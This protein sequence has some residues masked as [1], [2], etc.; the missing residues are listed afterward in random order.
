MA[1][2]NFPSSPSNGDF[3]SANGKTWQYNGTSWE[4][5]ADTA[6]S[7][8]LV[9]HS[10]IN[11][12]P[13]NGLIGGGNITSNVVLN[14]DDPYVRGLFSGT[15]SISYNSST[16]EIA[17]TGNVYTKTQVDALLL[18]KVSDS[19]NVVAGDG[20]YGGGDLSTNVTLNISGGYGITVETDNI[21][22]TASDV[23]NLFSAAGDIS[24]NSTTGEF[25]FTD[26]IT[27]IVAGDGLTGG[28]TSTSVT[29]DVGA[30]SGIA[31]D[32]GT[33][34]VDSTVIRTTGG[35]TISGTLT[36][37]GNI[38]APY[39]VGVATSAQYADLAER[40]EADD[41]YDPATVMMFGGDKELTIS[42]VY[43]T[44]R[45]AGVLSSKPGFKMNSVAGND[46][47]HPYL[48][49]NGRVPCKVIGPIK[50]GDLLVSSAVVGHA[51]SD[52]NAAAGTIIGK[53][54]GDYL[55]TV[56]GVIE[57]YVNLM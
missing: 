41:I 22:V 33:V 49:L 17:Y 25:S 5:Y 18:E 55:D 1:A 24:Y 30:G 10:T 15:G 31:V 39:F 43:G 8:A 26:G 20:L 54:L 27:T 32:A 16:G 42:N 53:A 57:I 47:T 3:Y 4:S 40:Y 14:L 37:T 45:V 50:K 6:N 7:N 11:I 34:A 12:T 21:S 46:D 51:I 19:V 56:P 2:L 44:H 35:Q 48:A 38:T 28:G 29:I 52:N 9:D 36:A 13:G 23:R